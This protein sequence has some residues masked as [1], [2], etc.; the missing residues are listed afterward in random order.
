[1]PVA[2]TIGSSFRSFIDASGQF[3]EH[4]ADIS[5][6]ALAVALVCLLG[7][8]LARARAWQRVL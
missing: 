6:G 7:M 3:F 8:Y 2:T 4:L 1:M 5:W